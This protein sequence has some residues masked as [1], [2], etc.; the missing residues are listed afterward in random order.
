M[1][2][3]DSGCVH[4]VPSTIPT[5][6]VH[7]ERVVDE[8]TEPDRSEVRASLHR[9]ND[10]SEVSLLRAQE[11]LSF[12]EGDD[13]RQ[14]VFPF[15]NDEH[16]RCVRTRSMVLTY[17]TAVETP[18]NEIQ[19]LTPF[20]VL[21]D[22]KLRHELPTGSRALVPTDRY[23]ERAFSVDETRDVRVQP[24]LLIV[25]T[26]WIFTAHECTLKRG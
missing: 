22:V 21:T 12:E 24:F 15:A 10:A 5:A 1:V 13:L 16:Q 3:E 23:V 19:D 8:R 2:S 7:G 4:S 14:Q 18:G 25:R 9:A 6:S 20:G 11:G 26:A 17:P